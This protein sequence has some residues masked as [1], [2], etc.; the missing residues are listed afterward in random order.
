MTNTDLK[1]HLAVLE[2][3]ICSL[4]HRPQT[5]P[6]A[7]TLFP[8]SSVHPSMLRFVSKSPSPKK[9]AG[10]CSSIQESNNNC[11]QQPQQWV[12][13]NSPTTC[14]NPLYTHL[15]GNENER[16]QESNNTSPAAATSNNNKDDSQRPEERTTQVEY[17]HSLV[18]TTPIVH[19]NLDYFDQVTPASN[20]V[21]AKPLQPLNNSATLISTMQRS[22]EAAQALITSLHASY[23]PLKTI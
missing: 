11:K 2:T 1:A 13:W 6:I 8:S 17:T 10:A 5:R 22:C 7:N 14:F 18:C 16:V 3:R 21:N 23:Q 12:H 4:V 9:P 20:V 15:E 19:G